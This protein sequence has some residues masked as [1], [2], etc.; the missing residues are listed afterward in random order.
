MNDQT[1]TLDKT[2]IIET[3][4]NH[5]KAIARER[6][7][8]L[9]LDTNVIELGL[10]S[11]ERMDIIARLEETYSIRIPE[12]VLIEVETCQE[13]V[14]ALAEQLSREKP[15]SGEIPPEYYQLEYLPEWTKLQAT[16]KHLAEHGERNPFFAMHES[17]SNNLTIINGEEMIN[18]SGNN[19]LGMSGD[20]EVHEAAKDAIDRYGT[21][22]SASRLVS[23]T[24]PIHEELERSICEFI[25]AEESITF[26][27][28]HSTNTVTIGHL[29]GPGDLILHDDLVHNSILVGSMLSGARRRPF[30]HND[31]QA[32]DDILR[33]VRSQYRKV[34]VI[35]EGVYSMDG[36]FPELPQF[37]EVKNRHKSLL[38]MDEAHSIGTMGPRGRGIGEYYG[39][40]NS[41]VDIWMG[42]LSKALGACGGYIAGG[43]PLIDYM[44]H[45]CPGVIFTIGLAPASTG[46]SLKALQILL[47]DASRVA[48][49]QAR[50]AFFLTLARQRGFNTGDSAETPIIPVILGNSVHSLSASRM[51]HERGI[52]VQPIL[53]PAVEEEGARLRFFVNTLHTNDQLSRTADA[54]AEV[55]GQLDP[56]YLQHNK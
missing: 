47:N 24:R 18:Y 42:T 23:G 33:E 27:S 7:K 20:P 37:I 8:D 48:T 41:D 12:E 15:P 30:P 38:M 5:V 13:I 54:L 10:D 9:T 55:L 21:S 28:G 36:D 26:T 17:I 1:A 31:W 3:V 16:F 25:G 6:A 50:A 51:M 22:V 40:K 56:Q 46:A 52:S 14:D 39:V 4:F 11:L 29:M 2:K 45:T 34:L 49:L 44:K 53:H 43:K 35:I 19:Y 32:L